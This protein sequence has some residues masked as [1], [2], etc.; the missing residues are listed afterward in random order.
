MN[1]PRPHPRPAAKTAALT[2]A[3]VALAAAGMPERAGAG[4]YVVA[5]CHPGY[6]AGHDDAV[7][8]RSSSD[9]TSSAGCTH[10]AGGLRV[11]H[12]ASTTLAGR[13]GSWTFTAPTGTAILRATLRVWGRADGGL[14][15][16]VVAGV[17]G[18]MRSAGAAAGKPHRVRWTGSARAVS[19][20]LECRRS[21]HCAPS[22]DA[23]VALNRVRLRLIDPLKP[24][25]GLIGPFAQ[26][27]VVRGT[28]PLTALA[29]D[30]G[31][32]VAGI[33]LEVNGTHA[34]T[35]ASVCSVH[36]RMAL[37][38]AP[39]PPS[40]AVSVAERTSSAPFRQG[41]N[42]VQVCA[43][44]YAGNR[45]ANVSCATRKLRVDNECPVSAV[46][47]G[48]HL[49][50]GVRGVH[51]GFVAGRGDRPRVAG[52]LVD[53]AGNPVAGARVCVA[54]QPLSAHAPERVIASPL[55]GA[56]GRFRVPLRRG[57]AQ[58]LRIAYWPGDSGALQRFSRIR[59]R[60]RPRLALRPH[61]GLGNGD[62]LRFLVHL[63][64]PRASHRQVRIE[65][66][67]RHR[68][69]PVTGGRTGSGGTYRGRYRFHATS[70][71]RSYGF[72][73]LVP[74]QAGYPYA[75]GASPVKRARVHG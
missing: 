19:A 12:A 38:L 16:A 67:L 15:P 34:A 32:G 53:A 7:F 69:V 41:T 45:N 5:Q 59:F 13:R 51:R 44:D 2:L 29:S 73:A 42:V 66:R 50:A 31:S 25:A 10:G 26:Q 70:G 33:A 58:R 54:G 57:P 65:A 27:E 40:A 47:T 37:R 18:A 36:G 71:S 52:R 35:R 22:G 46:T 24:D 43:R 8:G 23:R 62:R 68:W 61:R 14:A 20:R 11:R 28:Q 63:P 55:T 48:A 72:R 1:H 60:A 64:G 4:T 56:D 75:Q 74:H 17:P 6:G 3:A 30:T 21:P 9:F 49:S 39:C